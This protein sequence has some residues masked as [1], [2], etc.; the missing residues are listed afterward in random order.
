MEI[1]TLEKSLKKKEYF[2]YFN[3]NSLSDEDKIL[4]SYCSIDNKILKNNNDN[5]K[6]FETINKNFDLFLNFFQ[7]NLN[8]I[9]NENNNKIYWHKIIG[10]WLYDFIEELF[11]HWTKIEN[12]SE[13][14][15][16]L[17]CQN[18]S[19]EDFIPEDT[20]DFHKLRTTS[21]PW[22]NWLIKE[23]L[24]FKLGEELDL[25]P[26]KKKNKIIKKK[27]FLEINNFFL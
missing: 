2:N 12:F 23:C 1:L 16:I 24:K 15:K 20:K 4:K 5:L 18:F 3:K 7:K 21:V 14:Y 22:K 11:Y 19:F 13:K 27:F 25:Y 9:H 26:Q 10:E 8:H 17:G 6:S